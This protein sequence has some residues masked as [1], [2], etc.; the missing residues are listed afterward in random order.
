MIFLKTDYAKWIY[1]AIGLSF[2]FNIGENG[3]TTRLKT[4]FK[5]IEYLRIRLIE[6]GLLA[7]PFVLFLIYQKEYIIA[8]GL[9]G[10][11]IAI[12]TF[13]FNKN[14]NSVIPTPFRKLPFE[15][16][17]G[18]RKTI[19]LIVLLY[20]LVIKAIQVNNYNLGVVTLG[21]L[22]VLM[23]A[24]YNK[25]EEK[26]YVWIYSSTTRQFLLKKLVTIFIGA[27]IVS[28][29]MVIALFISFPEKID[30]TITI[31]LLGYV[32]IATA[33]LAKYSNYPNEMNIPAGILLVASVLFPPLLLIAI[34]VFYKKSLIKLSTII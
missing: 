32:I 23:M 9:L 11:A 16:I 13:S 1:P 25:T 34:P 17:V 19:L 21:F 8:F 20:F 3:R 6:N 24:Y 2:L 5:K 15:Y 30:V 31:L 29:P 22:Y 28:I 12:A 14:W 27:T 10:L 33:L 18:F 7:L 4:I 26:Y